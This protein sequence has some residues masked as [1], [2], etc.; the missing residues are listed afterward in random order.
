LILTIHPIIL[1]ARSTGKR[2]K[3]TNDEKV[4]SAVEAADRCEG[5]TKEDVP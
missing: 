1:V 3:M 2:K 4:N 5:E